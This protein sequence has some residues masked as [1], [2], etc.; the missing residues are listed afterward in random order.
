[1]VSGCFLSRGVS[2]SS[3]DE[4]FV[5]SLCLYRYL[6]WYKKYIAKEVYIYM[7]INVCIGIA[8]LIVALI[9]LA[10]EVYVYFKQK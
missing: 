8:S 5:K 9:A 7:D 3:L 10:F 6:I 2:Y 4:K 1:M